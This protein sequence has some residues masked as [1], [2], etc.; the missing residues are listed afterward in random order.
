MRGL[1]CAI[2]L[3]LGIVIILEGFR[4]KFFPIIF[5]KSFKILQILINKIIPDRNKI[6]MAVKWSTY[7]DHIEAFWLP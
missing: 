5:I 7:G 6:L 3:L 4:R 1:S 2:I